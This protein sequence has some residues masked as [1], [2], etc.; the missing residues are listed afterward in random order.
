VNYTRIKLHLQRRKTEKITLSVISIVG[1][2]VDKTW[3]LPRKKS[4]SFIHVFS[5]QKKNFKV[6]NKK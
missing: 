5:I 3:I 6:D 4:R 2:T 1:V